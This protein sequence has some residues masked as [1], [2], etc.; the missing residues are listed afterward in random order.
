MQRLQER[1]GNMHLASPGTEWPDGKA[2]GPQGDEAAL[3]PL[4]PPSSMTLAAIEA[5]QDV[6][7]QRDSPRRWNY[8]SRRHLAAGTFPG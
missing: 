6:A 1:I 2:T 8:V 4:V 3:A 5:V 7:R